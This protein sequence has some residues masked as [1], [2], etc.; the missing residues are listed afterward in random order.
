MARKPAAKGRAKTPQKKSQPAKPQT[1]SGSRLAAILST[2]PLSERTMRELVERGYLV[3]VGRGQYA[4]A[5]S[6]QGYIRFRHETEVAP[7]RDANIVASARLGAILGLGERWMRELADKGYLVKTGRGHYELA[8][9]VQGYNRFIRETEVEK[10]V[11]DRDAR[12][13][14]ETERARKLKLENDLRENILLET[15]TAIAAID[16]IVGQLRTDLSGVPARASE[17]VATRRRVENAI[18]DVLSGFADRAEKACSALEAGL[19]PLEADEE[20]AA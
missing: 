3:K 9:S 1:V 12:A 2:P 4:L 15:P 7:G 5:P 20:A 10:Q 17:D 19:D 14:F 13:E 16:F 18:D 11:K 6:V 8:A